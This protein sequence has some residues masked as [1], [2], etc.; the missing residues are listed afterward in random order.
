MR[1]YL[2]RHG[3]AITTDRAGMADD[4]RPLAQEGIEK[5][6]QSVPGLRSLGCTPEIILSSP[7]PR[8]RQT[9]E[10]LAGALE[11]TAALEIC[12]SLAPPVRREHVYKEIRRHGERATL[13][14]VGHQPSLGEI[15]AEIAW[16]TP[17]NYIELKKGGICALDFEFIGGM[18]KGTLLWLLTPALLRSIRK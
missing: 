10:I 13:M 7:L 4:E 11:V 16:G 3:I 14:L 2:V 1:L 17:H 8:A 6:N 18:P 15:A 9:A 12:P 5:L